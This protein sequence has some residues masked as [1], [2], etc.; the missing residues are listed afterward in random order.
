[1][2][3]GKE[4]KMKVDEI[5]ELENE[6]SYLLLL[7]STIDNTNYFLTVKLNEQEEPTNDYIVLKEITENNETYIQK[8]TDPIILSKLITEYSLDYESDY[9]EE[10]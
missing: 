10:A 9:L 6:T 5:I 4:D 7:D 2:K 8:V 3:K 1:M